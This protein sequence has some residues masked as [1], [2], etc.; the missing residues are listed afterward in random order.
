M[1]TKTRRKSYSVNIYNK[2]SKKDANIVVF[3]VMVDTNK[4][5]QQKSKISNKRLKHIYTTQQLCG[6]L[7]LL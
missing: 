6:I 4:K 2:H 7:F 1:W 3:L 5:I